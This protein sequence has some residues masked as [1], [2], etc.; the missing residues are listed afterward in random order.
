[1]KLDK[2]WQ[3]IHQMNEVQVDVFM[4]EHKVELHGEFN[5]VHHAADE[6]CRQLGVEKEEGDAGEELDREVES[7]R[8]KRGISYSDALA[9]LAKDPNFRERWEV[10]FQ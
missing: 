5:D 7:Y 8:K 9:Q 10:M 1:M 2:M 4:K 3:K 6:L